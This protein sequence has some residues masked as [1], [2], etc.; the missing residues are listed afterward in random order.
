M[1][2]GWRTL[3]FVLDPSRNPEHIPRVSREETKQTVSHPT[4]HS[5]EAYDQVYN[6]PPEQHQAKFSHELLAGA[7]SYEA[8]KHFENHQRNE[9]RA[10][11]HGFAKDVLAGFVGAEVDKLAE[12]KGLEDWQRHEAKQQ[13]RDN[14]QRMYDEYYITEQGA[15]QYDPMQFERPFHW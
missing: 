10:V 2:F 5:K 9:A 4:D 7:A 15:P 14:A 8:F 1:V 6:P 12:R 3:P 13:A 11:S